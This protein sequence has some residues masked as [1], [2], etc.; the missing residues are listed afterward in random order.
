MQ[1]RSKKPATFVLQTYEVETHILKSSVSLKSKSKN[2][3]SNNH[4]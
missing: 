1:T 4:F 3:T 2:G